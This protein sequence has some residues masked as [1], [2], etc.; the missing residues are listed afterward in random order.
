[1]EIGKGGWEQASENAPKLAVLTKIKPFFWNKCSVDGYKHLIAFQSYEKLILA[2]FC[3]CFHCFYG[4]E[5][6]QGPYSAIFVDFTDY[7]YFNI[8]C[9]CAVLSNFPQ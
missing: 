7:S 5:N 1:M 4:G 9:L 3:W 8:Y 2:L 6:F